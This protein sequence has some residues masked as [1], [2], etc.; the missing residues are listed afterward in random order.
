[1]NGTE[2]KERKITYLE[3]EDGS[4]GKILNMTSP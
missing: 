3:I 4:S 2:A 1:M